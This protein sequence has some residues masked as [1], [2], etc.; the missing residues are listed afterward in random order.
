MKV[1]YQS[2]N[3]RPDTI[4]N[5]YLYISLNTGKPIVNETVKTKKSNYTYRQYELPEEDYPRYSQAI[6]EAER[7]KMLFPFEVELRENAE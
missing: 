2:Q 4:T 5:R 6:K 3:Y 7:R 1:L